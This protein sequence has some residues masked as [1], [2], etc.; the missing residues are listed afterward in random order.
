MEC[1]MFDKPD[2]DIPTD[3]WLA[4]T[5]ENR[6]FAR[7][8]YEI[9]DHFDLVVRNKLGWKPTDIKINQGTNNIVLA[10]SHL[11][12]SYIFRVP[13]YGIQQLKSIMCIR[14]KLKGKSY[15]PDIIYY[16]D[17]CLIEHFADGEFLGENNDIEAFTALAVVMADVHSFTG[18][19]FGPLMY[20]NFGLANDFKSYY[21]ENI[22]N[23]WSRAEHF[24]KCSPQDFKILKERWYS[25]C[26]EPHS[27]PVICD[28]DL[29]QNNIF[30]SATN[31]RLTLID[32]D[33]CGVYHR[34]K[35]LHFLISK[36]I[37]DEQR[38]AFFTHYPYD[39]NQTLLYWYSFT[40]QLKYSNYE[41]PRDFIDA[42]NAFLAICGDNLDFTDNN[43]IL[44]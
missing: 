32:W 25:V 43:S 30:Y 1:L 38:N 12:Q 34:E 23:I 14:Q 42:A 39:V 40:M 20:Q 29:W 7:F 33:R 35:D 22:D 44:R 8:I 9:N 27:D 6:D 21:L 26:L 11:D 37:T 36:A 13:K 24:I 19:K 15:F 41:D 10:F 31:T 16:D 3:E 28:G 18:R 4:L 5:P 17:K 2:K